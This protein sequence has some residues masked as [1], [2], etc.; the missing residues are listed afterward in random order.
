VPAAA[1][2]KDAD[3]IIRYADRRKRLEDE[4]GLRVNR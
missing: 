2:D 1:F 4:P 3:F